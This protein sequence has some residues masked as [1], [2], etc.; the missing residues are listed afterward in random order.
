M[1]VIGAGLQTAGAVADG[2]G[3]AIGGEHRLPL[4]AIGAGHLTATAGAA[5]LAMSTKHGGRS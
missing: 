3:H 5:H 4:I 1:I 2:I